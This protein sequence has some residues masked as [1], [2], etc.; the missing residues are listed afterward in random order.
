MNY[1]RNSRMHGINIYALLSLG[2]LTACEALRCLAK[3]ECS[4]VVVNIWP[5]R[6]F[7]RSFFTDFL[8][9]TKAR[10][11]IPKLRSRCAWLPTI[12]RER[13]KF[14]KIK[15]NDTTWS[16]ACFTKSL[17][18]WH[19][20]RATFEL[21]HHVIHDKWNSPTR[22]MNMLEMNKLQFLHMPRLEACIQIYRK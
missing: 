3:W 11:E 15:P 8:I 12:W 22:C 16:I 20:I 5:L 9:T 10:D 13:E 6:T 7:Q 2:A 19:T 18:W 14:I 17:Q 1:C 4:I 21:F